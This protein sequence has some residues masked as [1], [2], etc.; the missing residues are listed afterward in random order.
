MESLANWEK[1]RTRDGA[2]IHVE[3]AELMTFYNEKNANS[4]PKPAELPIA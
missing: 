4:K 1:S 2:Q 3:W